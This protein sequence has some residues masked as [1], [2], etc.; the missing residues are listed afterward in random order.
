MLPIRLILSWGEHTY[1][2]RER[3]KKV[4]HENGNQKITEVAITYIRQNI[5]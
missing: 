1:A 2:E 4:L 3:W 5:I